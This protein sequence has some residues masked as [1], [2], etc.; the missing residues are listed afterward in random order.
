M[1]VGFEENFIHL[2]HCYSSLRLQVTFFNV[3]LSQVKHFC[4]ANYGKMSSEEI[5]FHEEILK[6]ATHCITLKFLLM[7][8]VC[9][10]FK[11]RY[12]LQKAFLYMHRSVS[13]KLGFLILVCFL[14]MERGNK[15]P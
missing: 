14:E 1:S 11:I 13:L 8:S 2:R 7:S 6:Q 15:D 4:S 12:V 3:F 5:R 9:V 10:S